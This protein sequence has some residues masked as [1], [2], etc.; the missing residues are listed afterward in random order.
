V[1]VVCVA[2]L[3]A[4]SG[5]AEE[6]KAEK[7]DKP[8]GEPFAGVFAF[9][10]KITL[11]DKQKE[12]VAALKKEYT[13][14]LQDLSAKRSKIITPERQQAAAAAEKAAK[15]EGKKSKKELQEARQAALKLTEQEQSEMKE[16]NQ[17]FGKLAKEINTKKMALLTDEQKASLKPNKKESK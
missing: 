9:N 7:K 12:A 10:K 13:P 17:A 4:V 6:K 14:Q 11:D 15:A 1:V 16:I 5:R 2:A 8:K 3:L